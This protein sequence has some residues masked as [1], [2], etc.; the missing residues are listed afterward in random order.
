MQTVIDTVH[1]SAPS[2]PQVKPAAEKTF[3][4]DAVANSGK[5]R[6]S[7]PVIRSED[8]ELNSAQR[9]QMQSQAGDVVRNFAIASWAVRK[10]L[11]FVSRFSFQAQTGNDVVDT[12]IEEL[13]REFS[14][15]G[16]CEVTRRHDLFRFIR[17]FEARACVDGDVGAIK[18]SNGMLQAVESDRIRQPLGNDAF[19]SPI[20][21]E[22]DSAEPGWVHGVNCTKWGAA[23]AYA[24]WKRSANGYVFERNIAARNFILHGYFDRF[25]QVRGITPLASGLNS[26]QDVYENFDYALAKAK[27]SQLFGI[28]F[29]SDRQQAA[30]IVEEESE[31]DEDSEEP[32]YKVDFKQ[33][34]MAIELDPGD[35]AEILE[36]NQPS[37]QFQNF[38]QSIIQVAL[39]SL[40]IPFCFYDESHTNY[41]GSKAAVV[42]YI[43]SCKHK[44]K[45]LQNVLNEITRWKIA[46]WVLEGR[47]V[48]PSGM[49]ASNVTFEWIHAGLPWW[50]PSKEIAADVAAVDS[51]LRTRTEIRKER[52]GDNWEDVIR[53]KA[54]EDKLMTELGIQTSQKQPENDPKQKEKQDANDNTDE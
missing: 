37:D 28:A 25:D 17:L 48:L 1:A 9:R 43:E 27:V 19:V 41:Y 36:S 52:F 45:N 18:L 30:G 14:E 22:V 5:R 7:T 8:Q 44:R 42:L 12:Q 24:V 10:H 35:K 50:D 20:T 53:E 6:V 47:L 29:F 32:R 4:Y 31:D 2:L 54:K 16:N 40:D 51:G 21:G 46:Q 15:Q 13:V 11:D 49:D 23:N 26:L 3:G 33:G 38:T 39:K 34:P